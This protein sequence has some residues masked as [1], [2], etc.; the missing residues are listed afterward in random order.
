MR[1]TSFTEAP[2]MRI[3]FS[4]G[5]YDWAESPMLVCGPMNEPSMDAAR[6]ITHGPLT[7]LSSRRRPR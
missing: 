2:A 3:E 6:P 5:I 7:R 1:S 4:G